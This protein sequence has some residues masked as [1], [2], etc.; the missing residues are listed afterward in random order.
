MNNAFLLEPELI[1]PIEPE[2]RKNERE[3]WLVR[4][5]EASA[6]V[7]TSSAWSSLKEVFDGEIERLQRLIA[8]EANKKEL[9]T[10]ELYRLQGKLEQ[11]KR[12]ALTDLLKT[13]QIELTN[14]R[15]NPPDGAG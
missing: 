8:Q 12:Y 11:A 2:V 4:M 7:L 13:Y 6:E 3:A 1:K 5:I 14:V 15:H 9:N 10:P